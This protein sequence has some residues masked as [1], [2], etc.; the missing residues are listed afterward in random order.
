MNNPIRMCIVCRKRLVQRELIRLQCQEKKI[1]SYSGFGR[2]FYVCL[3]CFDSN[4]LIKNLS[5]RYKI[6]DL[7]ELRKNLKEI[8]SNG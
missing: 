4:K 5:F 2:S 8:L 6:K 3:D 7:D 1:V